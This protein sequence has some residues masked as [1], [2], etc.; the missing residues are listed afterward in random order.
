M[1]EIFL[2]ESK[3]FANRILI[4]ASFLDKKLPKFNSQADDVLDLHQSL[5]DLADGKTEFHIGEGGTT[6]RFLIS[7]LTREHG[8]FKIYAKPQLLARPQEELY[9]I[10][11]QLGSKIIPHDDHIQIKANG[12]KHLS[13]LNIDCEKST[14]FAS[15]I[16]LCAF[17]LDYD[18]NINLLNFRKSI[19]YLDMTISILCDAG[20]QIKRTNATLLITKSSMVK[21]LPVAEPD[22]SSAFSIAA[23]GVVNHGRIL[24][25]LPL[26]SIQGD[27]VFIDILESMNIKIEKVTSQNNDKTYDL[28]I[29][30]TE[31]SELKPIE[32]DLGQCPDL[33]PVLSSLCALCSGTSTLNNIAHTRFKESDRVEKSR[34]LVTKSGAHAEATEHTM[35]ITGPIESHPVTA[36]DYDPDN[37]HRMAM[38]AA[39]LKAKE[40]PVTILDP[41]VVKKSYPNF[42]EDARIAP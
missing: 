3:S 33:L 20:M 30:H 29:H 27:S 18:L 16:M 9:E 13:T 15:G 32:F 1:H 23:M 19:T 31:C 22:M 35:K 12:W 6:F 4:I 17:G 39:V 5:T 10:L 28:K 42:W 7:R 25:D 36:F 26:K 11:R 14:Q 41:Q 34:E 38:A 37:D 21:S 2:S 8:D 40:I 24:K